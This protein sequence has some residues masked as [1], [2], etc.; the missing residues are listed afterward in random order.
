[1]HGAESKHSYDEC[2]NNPKI[3]AK[4]NKSNDYVKKCGNNAHFYDARRL[5]DG[6]ESPSG[7]DTDS[8]SDGE[9]KD[10]NASKSSRSAS[11]YHVETPLKKRSDDV[12][13]KSPSVK[14]RKALVELILGLKKIPKKICSSK[15]GGRVL[16]DVFENDFSDDNDGERLPVNPKKKKCPS[17]PKKK[18][19][20]DD[21]FG[22][23]N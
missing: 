9:I 1:M 2:R 22:F 13:H 21:A 14:K 8:Q 12:G 23:N 6:N 20:S 17:V 7:N 3:F 19:L 16:D 18:S 10:D 15:L 4:T 5:S 11:N